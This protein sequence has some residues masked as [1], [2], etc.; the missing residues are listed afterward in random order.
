MWVPRQLQE[1]GQGAVDANGE[2]DC[3]DNAAFAALSAQVMQSCCPPP[4]PGEEESGSSDECELPAACDSTGCADDFLEFFD[5]CYAQ[6]SALSATLFRRFDAFKAGCEVRAPP[7]F[8]KS[9]PHHPPFPR[10]PF[11]AR[12][13]TEQSALPIWR[14]VLCTLRL[15]ACQLYMCSTYSSTVSV[16][17]VSLLLCRCLS[18]V[19]AWMTLRS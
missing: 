14:L 13:G 3:G 1:Q 6:L 8:P 17:V 5:A 4:A 12:P 10:P 18:A 19:L 2:P 9:P 11:A 15:P 16:R 7:P